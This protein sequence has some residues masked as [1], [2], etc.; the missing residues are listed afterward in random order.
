MNATL[1]PADSPLTRR[2]FIKSGGAILAGLATARLAPT[3][4]L[5]VAGGPKTVTVPPQRIAALTRWPR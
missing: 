1:T 4:T 2:H 5:A 3:E